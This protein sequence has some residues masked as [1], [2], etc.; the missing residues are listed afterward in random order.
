M[1]FRAC[2]KLQLRERVLMAFASSAHHEV[3]QTKDGCQNA[4]ATE[5]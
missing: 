2:V 5:M 4:E 1:R 3:V